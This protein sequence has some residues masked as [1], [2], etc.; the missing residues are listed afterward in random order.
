MTS[1]V[2]NT[3]LLKQEAPMLKTN[4]GINARDLYSNEVGS[5]IILAS[6]NYVDRVPIGFVE[7][8]QTI[9]FAGVH[10]PGIAGF[11]LDT[12]QSISLLESHIREMTEKDQDIKSLQ[13]RLS[14]LSLEFAK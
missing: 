8:S 10:K 12:P 6:R 3:L 14:V 4:G 5:L 1:D 13:Q 9:L 2:S 11:T 7:I